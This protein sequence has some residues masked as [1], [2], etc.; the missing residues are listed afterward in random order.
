MYG[1][2]VDIE[3]AA[4]ELDDV[5]GAVDGEREP[6]RLHLRQLVRRGV[7]AQNADFAYRVT[8]P[9]TLPEAVGKNVTP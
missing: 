4:A 1:H 7:V 2:L 5:V 3:P 8:Y 9:I 6:V